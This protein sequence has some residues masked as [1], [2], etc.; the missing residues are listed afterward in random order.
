MAMCS[1]TWHQNILFNKFDMS[2][3]LN[4]KYEKNPLTWINTFKLKSIFDREIKQN[5]EIQNIFNIFE[6]NSELNF[7]NLLLDWIERKK[8]PYKEKLITDINTILFNK[9]YH[10]NFKINK[11]YTNDELIILNACINYKQF[12]KNHNNAVNWSNFLDCQERKIYFNSQKEMLARSLELIING[13][14][15]TLSDTLTTPHLSENEQNTLI[16]I[17]KSWQ[18]MCFEI[19]NSNPSKPSKIVIELRNKFNNHLI[20]KMI[21]K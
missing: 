7:K 11:D 9:N 14:M 21:N 12:N 17:V 13:T 16:N 8:L 18:N 1:Q 3:F 20:K 15:N 19:V 6:N 5:K 4:I 2:F 10:I